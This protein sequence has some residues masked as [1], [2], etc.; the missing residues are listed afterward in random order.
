MNCNE[1]GIQYIKETSTEMCLRLGKPIEEVSG[2][3]VQKKMPGQN[4][5]GSFGIT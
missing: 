4:N 5:L 2:C 1:F 3:P